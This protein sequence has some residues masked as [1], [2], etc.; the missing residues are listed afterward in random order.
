MWHVTNL[1][2]VHCAIGTRDCKIY[3]VFEGVKLVVRIRC[4]R[5]HNCEDKAVIHWEIILIYSLSLPPLF[6]L[7]PSVSPSFLPP[8]TLLVSLCIIYFFVAVFTWL[9]PPITGL[10]G[11]KLSLI[12]C[13]FLYW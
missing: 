7:C 3:F 10:I 2:N 8:S 12:I 9:S 4:V 6:P 5:L 13:G 11:D 1:Y